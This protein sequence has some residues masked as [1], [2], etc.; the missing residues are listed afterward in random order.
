MK[1][2][3]V[4]YILD[5]FSRFMNKQEAL[6]W[7]HYSSEYKLTHS[8]NQDTVEKRR[9]IYL[10]KGLL[11]DDEQTLRLLENGIEHFRL[12]IAE[13]ILNENPEKIEFNNCPKCDK[14]ARTPKAK[15]CRHCGHDWR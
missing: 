11:T 5:Y 15:Q 3:T 4:D 14:L 2:E 9:K 12:K 13:R 7:R 6:A 1:P 8:D 10:S